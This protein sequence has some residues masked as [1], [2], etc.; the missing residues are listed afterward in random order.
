LVG[1]ALLVGAQAQVFEHG[2][3]GKHLA[4]FRDAGDAGGDDAVRR[5]A[6]EIGA[7]E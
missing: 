7:G 6:G 1:V 5:H 2:E 4:P 3:L